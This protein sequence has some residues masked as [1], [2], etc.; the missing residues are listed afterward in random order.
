MI[1]NA[2][3]HFYT[4]KHF[5][6]WDSSIAQFYLLLAVTMATESSTVCAIDRQQISTIKC[7]TQTSSVSSV[8]AAAHVA[9]FSSL[10]PSN[11]T[12]QQIT[13]NS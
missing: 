3:V 13:H 8:S 5:V 11:N 7:V 2:V 12:T 4:A 1:L 6:I 10:I 9:V